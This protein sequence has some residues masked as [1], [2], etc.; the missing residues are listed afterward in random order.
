M[1]YKLRQHRV[2]KGRMKQ[3]LKV[4]E[5]HILSFQTSY[6]W[7][8]RFRTE[9]ERKRLHRKVYENDQWKTAIA[10]GI[11]ET[12]EPSSIVERDLVPTAWSILL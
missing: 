7:L 9:A 4:M 5:E 10:P 11:D 8:R 12:L 6:V 1:I 2:K 3:W